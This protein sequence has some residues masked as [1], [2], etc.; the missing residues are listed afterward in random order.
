VPIAAPNGWAGI[1]AQTGK[2]FAWDPDSTYIRPPAY[3]DGT[4]LTRGIG[5]ARALVALGDDVST[6]HI[7]PVGGI[8][9]DSP[10]GRYLSVRGVTEFN[11]YGSRR[12]NHEV[13][14]RGTFSNPRLRNRLV[15]DGDGRGL[16]RHVP[17][18]DIVPVFE[19]AERYAGTPLIV[20]AGMN[21]GMGSSRDWAAKGPWLLGVRAVLAESFERIHRANLCAM[22]ILPLLLPKSWPA[23]GLTGHEEFDLTLDEGAGQV[24]VAAGDVAFTA[25]ADVHAAEWALLRSG[26]TLPH[27]A[28]RLA[29]EER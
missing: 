16:T 28:R 23:L 3:V 7:S 9:A 1:P 13:M 15:G 25:K 29:K 5:G 8:P 22:G 24:E 4:P 12:G 2:V 20:L 21:Y 10:A 26:G 6:D 27:L 18:G 14:A 11:S 19:A 17:T